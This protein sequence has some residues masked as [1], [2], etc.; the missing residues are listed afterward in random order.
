MKNL[1]IFFLFTVILLLN[2]S[3]IFAKEADQPSFKITGYIEKINPDSILVYVPRMKKAIS[4]LLSKNVLV[5]EFANPANKYPLESLK[6]KYMAVF[7]GVIS[8]SGFLC[9]AI[10]FVRN[11]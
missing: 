2:F 7:E 4:L 3:L 11:P 9:E 8:A 10:Y 6:E 5:A 1:K